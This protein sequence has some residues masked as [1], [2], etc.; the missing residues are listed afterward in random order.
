VLLAVVAAVAVLG[1]TA[2][3]V[4]IMARPTGVSAAC[5]SG[6]DC[7]VFAADLAVPDPTSSDSSDPEETPE[8]ESEPPVPAETDEAVPVPTTRTTAPAPRRTP[9]RT[10]TAEPTEEEP[11]PE[12]DDEE[13]P[14]PD[15]EETDDEDDPDLR[16]LPN[17][18]ETF[19]NPP[20]TAPP[21]ST[22]EPTDDPGQEDQADGTAVRVGFDVVRNRA[23]RYTAELS[24]VNASSGDL[25]GL[26]LSVPVSGRVSDAD[27]AK[28]SQRGDTLVLRYTRDVPAGDSLTITFSALGAPTAP[29]SC[30][31]SG[32]T[33]ELN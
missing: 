21:T 32:G 14:L 24:V 23:V 17:P 9:E 11:P 8:E 13:P 3:G 20:Q 4:Q 31:L 29:R 12:I 27:G 10:P 1:G 30:E 28:W 19:T 15:V 22:P 25:P 5:P 26:T 33:C 18:V 6:E 2:A 16:N 7:D